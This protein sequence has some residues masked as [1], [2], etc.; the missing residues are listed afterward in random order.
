MK[1]TIHA[2]G[3]RRLEPAKRRRP[4]W[5]IA[6]TLV[7]LALRRRVTK[8]ALL[9]C[10]MVLVGHGIWLTVVMLGEQFG[11][12]VGHGFRGPWGVRDTV[13]RLEEIIATYLQVQFYFTLPALAV[14][15]GGAVADD[16]HA[17]AFEL[18]FARPLSR[19]EYCAG[20][21]LGAAAVPLTTLFLATLF[22]WVAAIGIAPDTLSSDLWHLALPGLGGA[23]L[24][25]ALLTSM[26]VGLSAV[27]RRARNVG[28]AFVTL[29]VILVPVT[30]GLAQSGYAWGGYLSP[31]RDLRT[32]ID[33]LLDIGSPSIARSV[34]P[35]RTQV[36][37]D[38]F[39][40]AVA[41]GGYIMAGLGMLWA[42]V[43]REVKA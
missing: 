16:R 26:I 11:G 24:G 6:R 43:S 1:E 34:M 22:L 38:V 42:G 2:I 9:L 39:M 15:A 7:A 14:V 29:M 31:E 35:S 30:E 4:V 18:Y 8:F 3:Y 36:N 19:W 12:R 25:T 28:I 41:L 5:A 17:G 37:S 40:S 10:L 21:L 20:K 23:L 33:Y 13:G 32:I 27:S